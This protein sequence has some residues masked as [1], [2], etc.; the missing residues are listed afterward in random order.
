M[1][2]LIKFCD[3]PTPLDCTWFEFQDACHFNAGNM[4]QYL[5]SE[6]ERDDSYCMC[7]YNMKGGKN[8]CTPLKCP[9]V[10]E[11]K[12]PTCRWRNEETSRC[13]DPKTKKQ[14]LI[15]NM[16]DRQEMCSSFQPNKE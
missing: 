8:G 11:E 4:S 16:E 13:L 14:K 3:K 7:D 2:T 10:I 1:L 12:D 15:C 9:L 5:K 6:A